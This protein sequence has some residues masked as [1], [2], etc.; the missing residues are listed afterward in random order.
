MPLLYRIVYFIRMY[1]QVEVNK[2]FTVFCHYIINISAYLWFLLLGDHDFMQSNV[3]VV[4][5]VTN[6]LDILQDEDIA[7]LGILIF[8]IEC[9]Q[10]K[11][12]AA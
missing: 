12:A 7:F 6:S 8:N 10:C 5:P 2:L 9:L 3:K 11:A 1:S 4:Q